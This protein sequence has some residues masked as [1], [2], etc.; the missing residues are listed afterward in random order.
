LGNI[1]D[2]GFVFGL[3]LDCHGLVNI[4]YKIERKTATGIRLFLSNY[5]DKEA[6]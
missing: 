3:G 5:S 2:S 1:Q 4:T 6:L